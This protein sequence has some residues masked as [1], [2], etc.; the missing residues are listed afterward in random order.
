M[1]AWRWGLLLA[2]AAILP[3]CGRHHD[4]ERVWVTVH[5]EGTV[6]A[7]IWSEAEYWS[8][9]GEVNRELTV[10]PNETVQFSFSFENLN[11]LKVRIYRSTDAFK[12]FDDFW[13]HHDL[14]DLDE[15]VTITVVP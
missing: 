11:R 9:A 14:E 4:H 8:F 2:A 12:V 6:S 3:S 5:N 1:I 13:D 10:A 15:R 7:N